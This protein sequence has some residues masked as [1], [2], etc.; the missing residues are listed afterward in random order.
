[1]WELVERHIAARGVIRPT[2]PAV[3]RP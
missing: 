3:V 1:V 2:P